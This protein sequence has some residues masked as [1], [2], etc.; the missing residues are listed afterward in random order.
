[1]SRENSRS[2]LTRR[3][4]IVLGAAAGV[5][6]GYGSEQT[7]PNPR[8]GFGYIADLLPP[9]H[10][11]KPIPVEKFHHPQRVGSAIDFILSH[12]LPSGAILT[13]FTRRNVVPMDIGHGAEGLLKAGHVEAAK[14]GIEWTLLHLTPEGTPPEKIV[15]NGR[16]Q[17]VD[18]SGSWWNEYDENG[19]RRPRA[20]RGRTEQLGLGSITIDSLCEQDSTF[21]TSEVGGKSVSDH[22]WNMVKY[23]GR[24][25]QPDGRF[26]H[27]PTYPLAFPEENVRI[28]EG[29]KLMAKRFAGIGEIAKSEEATHMANR[30]FKALEVGHGFSYGMS[31]DFLARAMW[32]VGGRK[33]AEQD[34]ARAISAGKMNPTGVKMFD[35]KQESI[36]YLDRS[37]WRMKWGGETYEV[38]ASIEGAISLLMAGWITE[39][40]AYEKTISGLQNDSGGFPT[41][42]WG[43]FSGGSET[44]FTAGRYI[45]LERLMTDV[46]LLKNQQYLIGRK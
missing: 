40:E 43:P 38:A 8:E 3:D 36:S 5:L 13:D 30:A 15:L 21:F 37:N 34:I 19:E 2:G 33:I 7:F 16:E 42:F 46:Q 28:A 10:L 32:G 23:Q 35:M 39:A 27:R 6:S 44:I 9:Q 26:I 22:V 41:A 1:M 45:L 4:F 17:W 20:A 12:Q 31:Y 25:Q 14:A 18:Y 29:L 11:T 24:M